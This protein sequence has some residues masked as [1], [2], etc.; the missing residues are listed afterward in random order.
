ML[1]GITYLIQLNDPIIIIMTNLTVI[2]L[3]IPM[4][5]IFLNVQ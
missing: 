3:I 5:V 1:F 4:K 2:H